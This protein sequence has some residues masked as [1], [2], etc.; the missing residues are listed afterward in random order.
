[1]DDDHSE[2]PC[3]RHDNESA[4]KNQR[5]RPDDRPKHHSSPAR[6]QQPCHGRTDAA[7]RRLPPDT[8]PADWH[9][10][11]LSTRTSANQCSDHGA[12]TKRTRPATLPTGHLSSLTAAPDIPT[13]TTEAL[14]LRS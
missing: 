11:R 4:T 9:Q 5:L 13:A 1:M 12:V 14:P 7:P 6:A 10:C 8:R 2:L 3:N